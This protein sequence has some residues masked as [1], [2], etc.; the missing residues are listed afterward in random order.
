LNTSQV[1]L[2]NDLDNLLNFVAEKYE[3]AFENVVVGDHQLQILQIVDLAKY[4]DL[5]AEKSSKNIN[6]PFWAKIWPASILLGYYMTSSSMDPG[7]QHVL[8]IGCGTGLAG[9]FAAARGFNVVLSDNN[10]EALVFTKINILKNNLQGKASVLQAD[11]S[12]DRLTQK[13][14]YIIGSEV[15]YI[16]SLYRGLIK[17]LVFHLKAGP[18]SEVILAGDY[19]RH[20]KKFFQGA[21][22]EFHISQKNIG[23]KGVNGPGH[24]EKFL[25]AIYKMKPKK[26]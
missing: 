14:D 9:L 24:D 23:Y 22:K 19:R 18:S 7:G 1:L 25:C 16:D 21:E 8:E 6:L 26:I 5:L 10:P 4:I 15:A 13:F 17:F 3:V 20:P 11:F 2:E 12:K